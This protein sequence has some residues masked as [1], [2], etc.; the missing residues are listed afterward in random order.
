M[1]LFQQL[2]SGYTKESFGKDFIAALS[3]VILLVPQGLAY[4]LLAGFPPESGLYTGIVSLF[5]YPL[6]SSSK[7]LSVGPVAL[8]SIILLSGL[9]AFAEPGTSAYVELGLFVCLCAG[10]IQV[11]FGVLKLGW[12]INFL[13][14]PVISG[15]ISA[16][17]IVII[18]NQ[19][20]VLLGVPI[21]RCN[22]AFLDCKETITSL[23]QMNVYAAAIGI[24][25]M[26]GIFAMKAISRK[27]PSSLVVFIG[28]S[29][30]AYVI[31]QQGI[32]L[33]RIGTF[34]SGFPLPEMP[35]LA[36]K[37][38]IGLLLLSL[39]I[40]L[41]SFIDSSVLA[42]SMATKSQ[43]HRIDSNRELYGL[44]LAKIVGSIFMNI[45]SSGSF[46]R[47][48]INRSSG[49]H[50]QVS[51]ILAGILMLILVLF[52]TPFF[53]YSPKAMLAAIIISS[54]VKLIHIKEMIRLF[55]L[56]KPDF[57][58]MMT[59]FFITIFVGIQAGILSGILISIVF[60]LRKIMRPHYAVLGRLEDHDVYRN[61]KRFSEAS[62][63]ESMLIFRYD[64]DVYFA[65][66]DFFYDKLVEEIERRTV[67]K[68]V[69]LDFS[70]IG[71]IDSTGFD[72]LKLL[73]NYM[74]TNGVVWKFAGMK[75]PVRDLFK[76][77]GYDEI[78]Q[79]SD[80][81]MSIDLAV[82]SCD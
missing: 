49:S 16:T 55:R 14:N 20:N 45:P 64:D 48:E 66:C 44:G 35:Q 61:V 2:K 51:S 40:A 13:S 62:K 6:F 18:V 47:S 63:D 3:V 37:D 19:L 78:I 60:I 24:L 42:K 43:D 21:E 10:L 74:K 53:V 5:I 81:Y 69:I 26:M 11:L 15:F 23:G 8:A 68:I 70:S 72:T 59:C 80:C 46:A 50:S 58:A 67:L 17:A 71:Y 57:F 79:Q 65:N 76:Q 32:E 36:G 56:D 52:C 4:G 77:Y 25:S 34:P 54:V 75:G 1:L 38:L 31:V 28:S 73:S 29:I 7:F 12:L 41:M 9:S 82:A 39:V 33:D 27:I 22:N 30:A